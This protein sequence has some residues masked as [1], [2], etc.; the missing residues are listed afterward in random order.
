MEQEPKTPTKGEE[1]QE[2]REV[3]R[4][5]RNKYSAD[6]SGI[7][8]EEVARG[9]QLRTNPSNQEYVRKLFESRPPRFTR[10]SLETLAVVAYHQPVTRLEMEQ[11]RGVDCAGALKTLMERRLVK[12]VGEKGGGRAVLSCW[13]GP[14]ISSR[15]S[16]F[17]APPNSPRCATSRTSWRR[18]PARRS[19]IL[20]RVRT[21]SRALAARPG[22][23]RSLR[24][25]LPRP[26]T[27]TSSCRSP[28]S[29]RKGSRTRCWWRR[30]RE[31]RSMSPR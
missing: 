25:N 16:R 2:V 1:A 23:G 28:A 6:A 30:R 8:V 26:S 24:P 17:P 19:R 22:R 13:A 14:G 3:V 5:V 7:L 20:P 31:R 21:F 4:I 10:P 15:S 27:G 12:V 11:I 29:C 9:I 18:R